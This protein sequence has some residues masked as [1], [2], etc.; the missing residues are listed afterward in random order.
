MR[1]KIP[2]PSC[3]TTLP[4]VRV[5]IQGH[6]SRAELHEAL[7]ERLA[8]LP[9]TISLHSSSPPNPWAGY[10]QAVRE[11]LL[12]SEESHCV[13]LQDDA[14]PCG[15]F[16]QKVNERIEERPEEV[17]SLWVGG[18]RCKTTAN[19]LQA[20][21]RG[22]RWCQ[23]FFSDICHV[24]GLVWPRP[25]AEHFLEWA[26]TSRLPGENR[27]QQSDDAIAGAWMRRTHNTVWATIPSLIEHN[28]STPSTI[29]RP[30]GDRGRRAIYFDSPTP[31]P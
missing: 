25:L 17:L 14:I 20:M 11:F 24:V 3:T 4:D 22:E 29:G 18:L 21:Q 7:L 31:L 10:E 13:L 5:V 12:N 16:I 15:G 9:V 28:D 23:I 6:P 30:Q 2:T 1:R 19:Y 27:P 8:P 26:A